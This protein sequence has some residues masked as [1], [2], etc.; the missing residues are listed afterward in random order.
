MLTT[1]DPSKTPRLFEERLSARYVIVQSDRSD[2]SLRFSDIGNGY[3]PMFPASWRDKLIGADIELHHDLRY[4][5]SVATCWSAA[6]LAKAPT[7]SDIDAVKCEPK[8]RSRYRRTY[9]RIT[10]PLGD[11]SQ[12][13]CASFLDSTI[14]LRS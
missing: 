11:G 10:L 8:T 13:L 5:R 6:I 2:G 4:A 1:L 12:L 3:A 7:L 14:D 9:S